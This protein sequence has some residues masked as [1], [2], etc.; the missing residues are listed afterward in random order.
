MTLL[1]NQDENE[2]PCAFNQSQVYEQ[3]LLLS[4]EEDEL[5]EDEEEEEVTVQAHQILRENKD[6]K[7]KIAE[8]QNVIVSMCVVNQRQ[9]SKVKNLKPVSTGTRRRRNER[10]R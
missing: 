4:T 3:R 5:E 10:Y 7:N 9:E 6:L 2:I 8:L 1:S